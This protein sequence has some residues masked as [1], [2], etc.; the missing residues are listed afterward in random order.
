MGL[1]GSSHHDYTHKSSEKKSKNFQNKSV[2]ACNFSKAKFCRHATLHKKQSDK[3][4]LLSGKSH[5]DSAQHN[6]I[7]HKIWSWWG[8][9]TNNCSEPF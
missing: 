6:S 7:I 2:T 9:M 4:L 1:Q 3:N 5:R 8:S